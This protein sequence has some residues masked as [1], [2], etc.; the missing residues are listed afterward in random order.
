MWLDRHPTMLRCAGVLLLLTFVGM[1]YFTQL[2]VDAFTVVAA[3]Y[4]VVLL[5][6]IY[7]PAS[8][9]SALLRAPAL[10]YFGRVSYA[11]YIFHQGVHA[12]TVRVVPAWAP[13]INALRVVVVTTLSVVVTIL[14]AEL[15]W[16]FVESRLIRRAHLR[17]KY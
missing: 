6:A 12:L 13:R 2:P 8:R 7:Q 15:S 3:F 17:Y 1:T 16:R 5:L 14:L 9:L 11:I 10:Q 4:T